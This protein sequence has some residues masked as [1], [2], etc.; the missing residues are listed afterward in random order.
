MGI[1]YL[2]GMQGAGKGWVA[3]RLKEELGDKL[4]SITGDLVMERTARRL[5]TYLKDGH[6]WDFRFWR[7]MAE[8]CNLRSAFRRT[9]MRLRESRNIAAFDSTKVYLAEATLLGVPEV[10]TE[11]HAALKEEDSRIPDSE[12]FWMR[13]AVFWL[14]VAPEVALQRI[15]E[16]DRLNERDLDQEEVTKRH[17]GFASTVAETANFRSGDSEEVITAIKGFLLNTD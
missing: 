13:S 9:I 15:K 8:S 1:A 16:R 14:D 2:I 11:F 4:A 7:E 5:C 12:S 10:R 17:A 6:G 3:K